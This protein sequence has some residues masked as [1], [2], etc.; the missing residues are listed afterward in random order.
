M[1]TCE[2]TICF[3]NPIGE[4]CSLLIGRLGYAGSSIISDDFR[5]IKIE[6][7]LT[8]LELIK[9]LSALVQPVE[10]IKLIKV[11]RELEPRWD[12]IT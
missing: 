4:F 9:E 12:L 3:Q 5:T 2:Y 10:N 6:S 8:E 11:S 7:D 1:V